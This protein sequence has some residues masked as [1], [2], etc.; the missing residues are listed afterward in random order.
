MK[1]TITGGKI[2]EMTENGDSY[3]DTKTNGRITT[4]VYSGQELFCK[5][6]V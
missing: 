2:S 4:G 3:K 6:L 1:K 5:M